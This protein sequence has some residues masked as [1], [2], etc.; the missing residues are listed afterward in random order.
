MQKDFVDLG[1]GGDTSLKKTIS[2][3]YMFNRGNYIFNPNFQKTNF[4]KQENKFWDNSRTR[5][6][7]IYKRF[8]FISALLFIF[9]IL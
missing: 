5:P 6:A 3:S 8:F 2:V 7:I 1:G 9:K 4:I